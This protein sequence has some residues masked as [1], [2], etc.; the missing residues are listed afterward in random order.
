MSN[1]SSKLYVKSKSCSSG[2]IREFK[3][4]STTYIEF[5]ARGYRVSL[6]LHMDFCSHDVSYNTDIELFKYRVVS[7]ISLHVGKHAN[8]YSEKDF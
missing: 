2:I 7:L 4:I 1:L 5:R 3:L 6:E 8:V